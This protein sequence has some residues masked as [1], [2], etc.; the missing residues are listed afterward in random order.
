MNRNKKSGQTSV[1]QVSNKCQTSVNKCVLKQV[2][3]VKQVATNKI[4]PRS[5][6]LPYLTNTGGIFDDLDTSGHHPNL[7]ALAFGNDFDFPIPF[8]CADKQIF[9]HIGVVTV[10]RWPQQIRTVRRS[11]LNAL[12]GHR[13][14]GTVLF[15]RTQQSA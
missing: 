3:N 2:S 1:K 14:V 6:L 15:Q 11:G 5:S 8:P 7:R 13:G 4:Q 10:L 12:V 9:H